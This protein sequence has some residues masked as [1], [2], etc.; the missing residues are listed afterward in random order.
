MWSGH[1]TG[2]AVSEHEDRRAAYL[3][4]PLPIGRL[5][6]ETLVNVALAGEAP[7][8]TG[9]WR[10][11]GEDSAR[12]LRVVRAEELARAE[13]RR[14]ARAAALTDA[15]RASH[16]RPRGQEPVE[17]EP[18]HHETQVVAIAAGHRSPPPPP[19]ARRR[20]FRRRSQAP[21]V[22]PP[23]SAAAHPPTED[24]TGPP[25][26][27]TAAPPPPPPMPPPA[28]ESPEPA[29][30]AAAS[31]P[32]PPPTAPTASP[33][34][35]APVPAEPATIAPAAAGE[36][37]TSSPAVEEPNQEALAG[38]G[39]PAEH[40][41]PRPS[42]GLRPIAAPRRQR[43]R[44]EPGLA[45]FARAWSRSAPT[46]DEAP[47]S[48]NGEGPAPNGIS[49]EPEPVPEPAAI[50]VAPP[51]LTADERIPVGAT[52]SAAPPSYVT[53]AAPPAPTRAEPVAPAP[54]RSVRADEPS[55]DERWEDLFGSRAFT[56][57]D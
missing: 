4:S 53:T 44:R 55:D 37:A 2:G 36:D 48:G 21:D 12:L 52:V 3:P 18:G 49:H 57:D 10:A 41:T 56:S 24:P 47:V 43:R 22:A 54:A 16:G 51:E 17:H 6:A 13:A 39:H 35:A 15:G 11:L 38:T 33:A 26:A 1:P 45:R 42:R 29:V 28:P 7:M 50:E 30:A 9:P 19:P 34:T 46:D 8:R 5:R 27:R 31:T 25:P 14:L 20:R 23:R 40:P 32:P